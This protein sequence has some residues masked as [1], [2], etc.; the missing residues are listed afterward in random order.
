MGALHKEVAT[1]VDNADEFWATRYQTSR[2]LGKESHGDAIHD[3]NCFAEVVQPVGAIRNESK[4]YFAKVATLGEMK[5]CR[6][7]LGEDLR[8]H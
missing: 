4:I 1:L 2:I 7:H 6:G 5:T 8:Q 3:E